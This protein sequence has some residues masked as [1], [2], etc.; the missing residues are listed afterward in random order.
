MRMAIVLGLSV[1]ILFI[2]LDLAF[3]RHLPVE[4]LKV[5]HRSRREHICFVRLA[6]VGR[7]VL[8]I[9]H[10]IDRGLKV[11]SGQ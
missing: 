6:R 10:A 3:L 8:L 1:S 5:L 4:L 11:K 2:D 9:F 7:I